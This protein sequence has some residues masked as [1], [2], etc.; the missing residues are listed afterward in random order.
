[1]FTREYKKE[2]RMKLNKYNN[3]LRDLFKNYQ[4]NSLH[5]VIMALVMLLS[6]SMVEKESIAQCE[7]PVPGKFISLVA[8]TNSAEGRGAELWL[9]GYEE[10]ENITFPCKFQWRKDNSSGSVIARGEFEKPSIS[11]SLNLQEEKGK[12]SNLEKGRYVLITY[13]SSEPC[14]ISTKKFEIK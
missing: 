9:V 10:S 3:V 2:Q 4:M 1:M 12:I 13:D 5:S 8:Q 14:K 7:N 6:F 11:T